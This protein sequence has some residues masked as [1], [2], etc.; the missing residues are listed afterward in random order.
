MTCLKLP[1]GLLGAMA[2]GLLF[3]ALAPGEASFL[4]A[5][6]I[7]VAWCR[8]LDAHAETLPEEARDRPV[9]QELFRTSLAPV[10]G[11]VAIV[12]ER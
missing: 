7:A 3:A 10:Q 9:P 12:E 4:G 6:V 11:P 8:W 5:A 2:L 1:V